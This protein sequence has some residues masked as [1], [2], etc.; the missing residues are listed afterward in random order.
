MRKTVKNDVISIIITF[1]IFFKNI[2]N[3][4]PV[5][6]LQIGKEGV[7][8]P[9]NTPKVTPALTQRDP[10]RKLGEK[11]G[12]TISDVAKRLPEAQS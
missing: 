12:V 8:M 4:R 1:H 6:S 11:P 7:K 2:F 9:K 10:W 3:Y 5:I